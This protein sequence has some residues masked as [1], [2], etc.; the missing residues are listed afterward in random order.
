VE[1]E[2]IFQTI[3]EN[4]EKIVFA[5]GAAAILVGVFKIFS[6]L[7]SSK[8]TVEILPSNQAETKTEIIVDVAGAVVNPGVYKLS[9]E[10]RVKDA[11]IAAGGFDQ[12]ADRDWVAKNL[13][14]AQPLVDGA[15][16]YILAKGSSAPA[17]TTEILANFSQTNKININ[18]ANENQLDQLP[19]IG[20]AIAKRI[21]EYREKN[22]GFKSIEEIKSVPGIG[23]KMF[24][25]IKDLITVF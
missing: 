4:Q 22:Q 5:L 21:I 11:L 15:K 6:S 3:Y 14:L 10:S 20:P 16:I 23:E 18:L 9:P 17:Q 19:G 24:E 8:S 13:N 2:K 1:K 7:G 12:T 25:K